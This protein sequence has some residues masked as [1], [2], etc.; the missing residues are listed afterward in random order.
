MIYIER[1]PSEILQKYIKCIWTIEYNDILASSENER[2][3]PDGYTEIIV[4]YSDRFKCKIEGEKQQFLSSSFVS[5]PFTK[6]LHLEATGKVGLLGVRFWPGMMHSFFNIPMSELANNYFDLSLIATELSKE[7]EY[8]VLPSKNFDERF[9]SVNSV[10]VKYLMDNFITMNKVVEEAIT[11]IVQSNGL[12]SIDGLSSGIGVGTRQLERLFN[13]HL[14]MTP[15]MF[16][17]IV[18]FQSIFRELES[19]DISNW[20]L[21][22]LQ[23]GYYDQAHFIKEFKQFSGTNPNSYFSGSNEL[24]QYFTTKIK[25]SDLYNTSR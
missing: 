5:G 4:N 18:R 8:Q 9:S 23:C 3:L 11:S 15:K 12:L 1:K 21:L 22:A 16:S 24:T 13:Q 20:T 17:R 2:I 10:L 7:I 19:S 14:G 6:Y 25:M